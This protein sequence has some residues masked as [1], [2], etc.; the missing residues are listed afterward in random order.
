MLERKAC[1]AIPL[2]DIESELILETD[3]LGG[4]GRYL[5]VISVRESDKAVFAFSSANERDHWRK[6]IQLWRKNYPA[7]QDDD[8][9]VVLQGRFFAEATQE[10][11]S[12]A[13]SLDGAKELGT[14]NFGKVIEGTFKGAPVAVKTFVQDDRKAPVD[15]QK[16]CLLSEAKTF[17]CL[18]EHPH[19][20]KMLAYS[21]ADPYFLVL[22]LC[23]SGSL[24]QFCQTVDRDAFDINLK[25]QFAI[26][27]CEGLRH[28]ASRGYCHR[29]VAARNILLHRGRTDNQ[30]RCKVSDFGRTAPLYGRESRIIESPPD[31][32]VPIRWMSPESLKSNLF[33]EKSDVWAYGILLWEMMSLGKRPYENV[34]LK[35]ELMKNNIPAP[36]RPKDCPTWFYTGIMNKCWEWSAPTRPTF[37]QLRAQLELLKVEMLKVEPSEVVDE[38]AYERKVLIG[39]DSVAYV[40][41]ALPFLPAAKGSYEVISVPLNMVSESSL[42][43]LTHESMR[44]IIE[45]KGMCKTLPLK[46]A[47]VVVVGEPGSGKS[48]TLSS[49]FGVTNLQMA[50]EQQPSSLQGRYWTAVWSESKDSR[51]SE[52]AML[53][54]LVEEFRS[55][56]AGGAAG[57]TGPN[58]KQEI[59]EYRRI[60][61]EEASNSAI[62]EKLMQVSSF[63]TSDEYESNPFNQV[64]ESRVAAATSSGKRSVCVC[65]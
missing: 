44:D 40:D 41:A 63:L 62:I 61:A 65:E 50:C 49:V 22:E 21:L 6:L 8:D 55:M 31:E 56:K 57:S 7:F 11:N 14:G 33:S 42:V 54:V 43:R 13:V 17:L 29:D 45:K 37:A 38:D 48:S 3:V 47:K 64:L 34:D 9:T 23:A 36:Q 30:V 4:R 35:V 26:E 53:D 16:R 58:P 10:A 2:N 24:L 1:L 28:I 19:L 32:M 15:V 20:L 27:V 25:M 60:E 52:A 46:Y 5:L 18:G 51:F 12:D 59:R 39:E